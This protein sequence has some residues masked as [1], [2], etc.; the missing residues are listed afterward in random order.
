MD[1][2]NTFER[3]L[4]LWQ[5]A[6]EEKRAIEL[7]HLLSDDFVYV[8]AHLP[9]TLNGREAFNDFLSLFRSRVENAIV[10]SRVPLQRVKMHARCGFRLIKDG[11]ILGQGEY[12]LTFEG[13]RI[14]RMCGFVDDRPAEQN[15]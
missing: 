15:S 2:Q 6:D 14:S 12:F 11:N 7:E 5:E 10:E 1:G 13:D 9:E 8:D 3:V 4:L